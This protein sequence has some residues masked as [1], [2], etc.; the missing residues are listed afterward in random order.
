MTTEKK[1][2]GLVQK[3]ASQQFS[4]ISGQRG[5]VGHHLIG[6]RCKL[7]RHDLNNILPV[8]QEEHRLIHD[9]NIDDRRF[10]TTYLIN[11]KNIDYKS[12]LLDN[13]FLEKDFYKMCEQRIKER[14]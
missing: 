8:T 2:D 7:L 12:Y 13:G 10:I 14:L 1:L 5:C 3:W 11:Q 6:R 9:G 4:R